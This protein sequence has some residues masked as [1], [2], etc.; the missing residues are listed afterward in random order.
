MRQLVR[1]IV[2]TLVLFALCGV[3]Y[4][5]AGW[6]LS[7]AAFHGQANG[8]IARNGST[9]IGQPWSNL[10]SSHPSIDPRW[11]QGR[12]DADNPLGLQYPGGPTI[13][14][15]SG[16]SNL[17][18]RSETLVKDVAAM[19]ALWK[20]VGVDDPTPDLVTTSGSGIDP[21]ITPAD[22][23]VQVPMVATARHLSQA[24]LRALISRETV[25][26]QLGFFGSTT[27]NVL[28]LN[29]ALAAMAGAQH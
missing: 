20:Q 9:L 18:P 13:S 26:P 15:G 19:V 3:A 2:L 24:S 6:A 5:I 23:L 29:E 22:A 4:P 14:G 11:F 7:Q 16:A 21:D 28:Q 10:T 27:I 1:A 17:G 8:S 25:G 12:P